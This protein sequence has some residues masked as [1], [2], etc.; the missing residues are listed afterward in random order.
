MCFKLAITCGTLLTRSN[1]A[2]RVSVKLFSLQLSKRRGFEGFRLYSD[3]IPK[4]QSRNNDDF[5]EPF[6][7]DFSSFMTDLDPDSIPST[8]QLSIQNDFDVNFEN[9]AAVWQASSSFADQE[10][11]RTQPGSQTTFLIQSAE[12]LLPSALGST[13]EAILLATAEEYQKSPGPDALRVAKAASRADS[14]SARH[15]TS[16]R[17]SITYMARLSN[18]STNLRFFGHRM[19]STTP[20]F[21]AITGSPYDLLKV[22]KSA[23]TAQIKSSYYDLVKSLHPDRAA[24]QPKSKQEHEDRLERFRSVVKAYELLKDPKTRAM[25]DKYGMGW[26]VGGT[27]SFPQARRNPWAPRNRPSTPAEWEHSYMWSEVLRRAPRGH[28]ASWQYA[29]GGQQTSDRFYGHPSMSEKEAE[30]RQKDAMPLNR[31]IFA[32]IFAVAWV[33]AIFQIQR[34]NSIGLEH[35]EASQRHSA[36]AAK[37][38]EMARETARSVEGQLRQRALMERVR[39]SK[40]S[41]QASTAPTLPE[42]E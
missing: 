26:D 30:Q 15:N 3:H 29:A 37:N 8:S 31:Q 14:V 40:Q 42:P 5:E 23:S 10:Q 17:R 39:Q 2:T 25:Y 1:A 33:V 32:A 13:E 28:R 38:L 35:T 16:Q 41:R 20:Y 19:F 4:T 12:K 7:P 24:T 6:Y 36:Q 11:S 9:S 18:R 27:G 34:L 21:H 22:P